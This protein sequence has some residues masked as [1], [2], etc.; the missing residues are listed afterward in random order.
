MTAARF[1]DLR[2]AFASWLITNSAT[3]LEV[4]EKLRHR[5]ITTTLSVYGHLFDGVADRL[6]DT[7]DAIYRQPNGARLGNLRSV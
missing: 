5:R 3:A 6:E 7:L 2:H 1:H 4:A